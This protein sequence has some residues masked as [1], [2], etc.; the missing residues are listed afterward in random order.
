MG[1]SRWKTPPTDKCA[2]PL[3]LGI[4]IVLTDI[5]SKKLKKQSQSLL[6]SKGLLG[7]KSD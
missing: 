1:Y 5:E 4:P 3:R 7:A 6:V 2:L